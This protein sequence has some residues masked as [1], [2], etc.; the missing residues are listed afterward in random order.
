[1]INLI[2]RAEYLK[3]LIGWKDKEPVKIIT[4]IRRCGK[5]TLFMLFQKYLL[6]NGV[7]EEQIISINLEDAKYRH[8]LNWE[9]LHDHIASLIGKNGK[10]YI[11][12]DEIQN[13]KDF[14]KAVN[15]L[16]LH[17]E[18]DIYLTGSNSNLLS[19]EFATLLRGRTVEIKMQPLSFKEYADAYPFQASR[20][21]KFENYLHNSSFPL[22]LQFYD[23]KTETWNVEQIRVILEGIYAGILNFDVIERH[24]IKDL[25]KLESLIKFIFDNIG[26][27]T[28]I[29]KISDKIKSESRVIQPVEV[30]AYIDA[31]SSSYIIYKANR[32]DV[33]GKQL[34]QTNAKYYIADIGL[35]Y[36]LLGR[37]G[38]IG[39]ILENIVY[40]ELLRRGYK[41]YVGKVG[42]SEVDF[43]AEG[44]NGTEYYQ[45]AQSVLDN[46]V[47][48][49][50]LAPL[51]AISDHNP[52]YLL[53]M[54][55]FPQT[56]YNGIKQVN[57]LDW[58]LI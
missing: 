55:Y 22:T 53:T 24:K 45:V 19:G 49:R 25:S 50:E 56:S 29:K 4:G 27:E 17:S 37:E 58:L 47:L 12:L 46:N 43:V 32:Y 42:A 3:Q 18:A 2:Q 6:E 41:V 10:T 15:S 8:L 57:I 38:D 28:S 16:R 14:Q 23:A 35:R 40:L 44:I 20:E 21:T 51:E 48:Q 13:V 52:K 33:K 30:D 7:K 54:D 36:F 39:H 9:N 26:S 1:M 11:F 31:L 34:L 5:S